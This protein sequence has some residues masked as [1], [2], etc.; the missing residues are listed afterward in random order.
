MPWY[1]STK[2]QILILLFICSILSFGIVMDTLFK[3]VA[4]DDIINYDSSHYELEMDRE[5][6][7]SRNE[8]ENDRHK[9]DATT[10]RRRHYDSDLLSKN[11]S[12]EELNMKTFATHR[13]KGKQMEVR[14]TSAPSA[15]L[16]ILLFCISFSH[17]YL[18]NTSYTYTYTYTYTHVP[19]AA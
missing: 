9:H 6:E 8:N 4:L 18:S 17:F 12:Y 2:C 13:T 5:R 16:L 15:T 1:S 10:K 3:A 14:A 19:I 7:L 11:M